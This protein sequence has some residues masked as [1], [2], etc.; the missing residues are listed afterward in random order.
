MANTTSKPGGVG[1]G[2]GVAVGVGV[3]VGGIVG[4]GVGVGVG[5]GVGG[6]SSANSTNVEKWSTFA[7]A[8]LSSMRVSSLTHLPAS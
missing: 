7:I 6:T 8:L 5:E 3:G 2:V 4:V 1:V